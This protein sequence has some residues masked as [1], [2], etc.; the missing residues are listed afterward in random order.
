[1]GHSTGP[2]LSNVGLRQVTLWVI[3]QVRLYLEWD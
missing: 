2:P 1:V 3:Q